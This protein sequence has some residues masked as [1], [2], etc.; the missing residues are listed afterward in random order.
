[1]NFYGIGHAM[2]DIHALVSDADFDQLLNNK[3]FPLI[4]GS[5]VHPETETF[6]ALL[7]EVLAIAVN[8]C[9]SPELTQNRRIEDY[10]V[11]TSGGTTANILKTAARF[12]T[13]THFTGAIGKVTSEDG[14]YRLDADALFLSQQLAKHFVI[15]DL[16][17]AEGQTGRYLVIRSNSG[18]EAYAACPSAAK[19][20]EPEFINEEYASQA[21]CM[22]IEGL[23]CMNKPL[24]KQIEKI[25]YKY[26][27]PLVIDVASAVGAEALSQWYERLCKTIPVFVFANKEEAA[28]LGSSLPKL[29]TKDGEPLNNNPYT[30]YILKKGT[31]GAKAW[32]KKS[33]EKLVPAISCSVRCEA[34]DAVDA[35]GAGDGF[36]AA[37]LVRWFSKTRK[38]FTKKT[39]LRHC[40]TLGAQ[41]AAKIVEHYGCEL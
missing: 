23:Q 9:A 31:D 26:E 20:L 39:L 21:D 30:V 32:Y 28:V 29:F 16:N 4:E 17:P 34:A 3:A 7:K 5:A 35:T 22:I 38:V 33:Q 10:V 18:R 1:M 6:N 13:I 41:T 11:R 36:A 24:M 19:L 8:K 14:S 12:G 15:P 2:I 25:C 40:L 27:V 37:F